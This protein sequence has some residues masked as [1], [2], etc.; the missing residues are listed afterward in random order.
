MARANTADDEGIV[1]DAPADDDITW[2]APRKKK[3]PPLGKVER[4]L[5]GMRD[6]ID[7][8][9]QLLESLVPEGVKR[10]VNKANNWLAD[11]TGM[12]AR[13]PEGGVGQAVREEERRFREGA[14][15]GVDWMRL[16]GNIVSPANLAIASRAATTAPRAFAAGSAAGVLEPTEADEDF[17]SEKAKQAAMGGAGGAAGNAALRTVARV[18]SPNA[19]RNAE[20]ALLKREGVEPTIGQALG[21]RA[22]KLEQ[23]LQ[24]A[25]LL[26]DGISISRERART[27]F[28]RAAINRA[29]RPVGVQVDDVGHGGVKQ[30]SE[31][32]D[33]AYGR[34]RGARGLTRLDPTGVSELQALRRRAQQLPSAQ[35]RA[36]NQ[37]WQDT[38]TDVFT[39][40]PGVRL[41]PEAL[42]RVDSIL[43]ERVRQFSGGGGF[44][45]QL[46]DAYTEFQRILNANAGRANPAAQRLHDAA[47][48]GYANLVRI[49]GASKAGKLTNGTFTPGHLLGAIQSADNSVRGRAVSHGDALMQDLA[50]AGQNVLGNNVPDSGTA[51][52]TLVN[53]GG[54]GAYFLEPTIPLALGAGGLAAASPH[55]QRL[56][57]AA[58]SKR[59]E[60]A[61]AARLQLRRLARHSAPAGASFAGLLDET[62]DEE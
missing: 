29:T 35:R 22:N 34:A 11:K 38:G 9:A 36:F 54:L 24:S 2:D 61:H 39:R 50:T 26:G 60:V 43:G 31:A 6:P 58:A 10:N 20:L 56:L 1:W 3:G 25:P 13:L 7:G 47:D 49:E 19:A 59:P 32:L 17:F 33:T 46:S 45:R 44:D 57:V 21:G 27:G 8:G 28:N 51:V 18:V 52:R 12:V 42:D 62:E 48:R 37:T 23:V 16:L 41:K 14:P 5:K 30:A 40:L 53:T 55:V 4:L 15:E